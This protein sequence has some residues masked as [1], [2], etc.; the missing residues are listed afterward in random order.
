MDGLDGK[1]EM[2]RV[3]DRCCPGEGTDRE[4]RG[5][6]GRVERRERKEGRG[7]DGK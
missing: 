2:G 7:E 1:E 3:Q 5:Q 4:R 6:R